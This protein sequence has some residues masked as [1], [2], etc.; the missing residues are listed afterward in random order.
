MSTAEK[1][2]LQQLDIVLT[3]SSTFVNVDEVKDEMA[4]VL[5]LEVQSGLL[6]ANYSNDF[7][8]Y[9]IKKDSTLV[10][11]LRYFN[12][13]LCGISYIED[14]CCRCIPNK[15]IPV[16]ARKSFTFYLQNFHKMRF[17]FEHFCLAFPS[18]LLGSYSKEYVQEALQEIRMSMGEETF[19]FAPPVA[20]FSP[21]NVYP[22]TNLFYYHLKNR[23][24]TQV[25]INMARIQYILQQ[26]VLALLQKSK[27]KRFVRIKV[28]P[29]ETHS[30]SII[31]V[32]N[33]LNNDEYIA[34]RQFLDFFHSSFIDIE[35]INSSYISIHQ[36]TIVSIYVEIKKSCHQGF[37]SQDLVQLHKKLLAKMNIY[38]KNNITHK[39]FFACD[40][41]RLM[42]TMAQ[43]VK[44]VRFV[45]DIPQVVINYD[46]QSSN[47]IVFTV[48]IVHLV[49]TENFYDLLKKYN[50]VTI[51]IEETKKIG[52]IKNKYVKELV[53]C[54]IA[55]SKDP[56]FRQDH[57]I[58]LNK[59]REIVVTNVKSILGEFRDF[60]GGMITD[61][62]R[63]FQ[64][65]R[66]NIHLKSRQC[67][68][69]LETFFYSVQPYIMV[70]SLPIEV[71]KQFFISFLSGMRCDFS[72][73]QCNVQKI[74]IAGYSIIMMVS[75]ENSFQWILLNSLKDMR[76]QY[77]DEYLLDKVAVVD[78]PIYELY[79]LGFVCNTTLT[80]KIPVIEKVE[81]M[82]TSWS[83]DNKVVLQYI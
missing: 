54:K 40:N 49:K 41:E 74:D 8:S 77:R 59:A 57:S 30:A 78:L 32:V 25:I 62:Y 79:A 38:I 27:N 14:R 13:D 69:F 81:Q 82:L 21:F 35:V 67:E 1:N 15:I 9:E 28:M 58:N 45:N 83:K 73:L 80:K 5:P 36:Q 6:R 50:G 76:I 26:R 31:I 20:L 12:E 24:M 43:L 47:E 22:L 23:F 61:Q 7:L 34:E 18:K 4:R 66:T 55:L 65:L 16:V 46:K 10:S 56:F 2:I 29:H 19:V 11:C 33:F 60:N 75:T 52:Y 71:L 70:A 39:I 68:F 64:K 42:K 3:P 37:S 63:I 53:I 48:G 72:D 17:C 44:E 51:H